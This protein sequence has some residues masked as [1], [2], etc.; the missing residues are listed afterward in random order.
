[1]RIKCDFVTNSSSTS[2]LVCVPEDHKINEELVDNYVWDNDSGLDED[3][4]EHEKEE[5]MVDL[6][7]PFSLFRTLRSVHRIQSST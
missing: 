1:M 4:F 2:F 3:E 5:V 7:H 6:I